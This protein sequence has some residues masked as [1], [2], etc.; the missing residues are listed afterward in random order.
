MRSKNQI[1][2]EGWIFLLR[3]YRSLAEH[4]NP[5]RPLPEGG[6][7]DEES[8]HKSRRTEGL[9]SEGRTKTIR[10]IAGDEYTRAYLRLKTE[11]DSLYR[12]QAERAK[13]SL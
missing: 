9:P 2:L 7:S 6:P 12:A 5:G 4:E 10:R 1:S 11:Y 3:A 8:P 13:L